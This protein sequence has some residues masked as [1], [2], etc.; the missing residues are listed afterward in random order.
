[1]HSKV[2]AALAATHAAVCARVLFGRGA[3]RFA[4]RGSELRAS[5]SPA[6][7]SFGFRRSNNNNHDTFR[8]PLCPP[9]LGPSQ[10]LASF[11]FV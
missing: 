1:M 8:L 2:N 6:G 3:L 7:G 11:S 4:L 10:Q 5:D 9:Q